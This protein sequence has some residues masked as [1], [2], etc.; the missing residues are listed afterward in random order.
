MRRPL[1]N[2]FYSK[3]TNKNS[4]LAVAKSLVSQ[5]LAANTNLFPH[6]VTAM[7]ESGEKEI[8]SAPR[9]FSLAKHLLAT[10]VDTFVVID[11]IDECN[12]EERGLLLDHL[13]DLASSSTTTKIIIL[14]RQEPDIKKSLASFPS[15]AISSQDTTQDITR[16]ISDSLLKP[17]SFKFSIRQPLQASLKQRLS[18][19]AAGNFLWVRL[20]VDQLKAQP[21]DD[22]E[23]VNEAVTKLPLGLGEMYGRVLIQLLKASPYVQ[24]LLILTLHILVAAYRPFTLA[25]LSQAHSFLKE[26]GIA[27]HAEDLKTVISEGCGSL[28]NCEDD[29]TI[30]LTHK[31]VIDF[32]T[33]PTE[34]WTGDNQLI[35]RFRVDLHLA[36]GKISICCME[37]LKYTRYK[38]DGNKVQ[39]VDEY[40]GLYDYASEFWASHVSAS[41]S[42]NYDLAQLVKEYLQSDQAVYWLKQRMQV[43]VD[44]AVIIGRLTVVEYEL[45]AWSEMY[46]EQ[47]IKDIAT[48][49]VFQLYNT[50]HHRLVARYQEASP[51]V[52][53]SSSILGKILVSK[54]DYSLAAELYQGNID[55]A[56]EKLPHNHVDILRNMEGLAG[57]RC[58][59]GR[60]REAISL[61]R[62]TVGEREGVLGSLDRET[63]TSL[64]QLGGAIV[65]SITHAKDRSPEDML[66]EAETF[67]TRSRDGRLQLLGREH[68]DCLDSWLELARLFVAQKRY[69]DAEVTFKEH[70][71]LTQRLL[72]KEHRHY[73]HS[74]DD[75]G[76][77]YQKTGRFRDAEG[78]YELVWKQRRRVLGDHH[79][80]NA[81]SIWSIGVLQQE[82][83]RYE[84]AIST[85]ALLEP[86]NERTHGA[87]HRYTLKPMA[88]MAEMHVALGN[89]VAA[90]P[91]LERIIANCDYTSNASVEVT[92]KSAAM[93]ADLYER[94]GKSRK[95]E[96]LRQRTWTTGKPPLNQGVISNII[97]NVQVPAL[98]A[99]IL[100][101]LLCL[102]AIW[103]LGWSWPLL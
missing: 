97:Q 61:L 77:L 101:V 5:I 103:V 38:V 17:G 6:A 65:K 57:V 51:E 7:N 66:K 69:P 88:R 49:C 83:S 24:K 11:A 94:A 47:D 95:A 39:S 8:T 37:I 46:S 80:D 27:S 42:P 98:R 48:N 79:P 89:D 19:G 63:M 55:K 87:S 93:L 102:L 100:R 18:D 30:N 21:F 26:T 92:T 91:L 1:T 9:C 40:D 86:F 58:L 29:G 60:W 35:S 4:R 53:E 68:P 54:G 73:L 20:M 14:S 56:S 28:I 96:S 59:Q 67:L 90:Q 43:Q 23:Q 75:L 78:I 82:Q 81:N 32:L 84:K 25:E 62:R 31:A 36:H 34:V 41:K 72:G 22:F 52:L 44:L 13:N 10:F 99:T 12:M 50:W 3:D 85:F 45:K 16:Y 2:Y 33:S 64:Q 74:L 71:E 15:Y 76:D 70:Q